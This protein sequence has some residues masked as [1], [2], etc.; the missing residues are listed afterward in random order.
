LSPLQIVV[1]PITDKFNKYG[2]KIFK[3]I[4]SLGYKVKFDSR[5]EKISYKIREHSLQK[6]P[7]IFIIGEK[8]MKSNSITIR[9]LTVKKQTILST[10]KVIEF[11]KKKIEKK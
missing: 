11:L 7:L 6:V 4:N 8:E 1:C 2:D 3:K 10:E 5:N 9:E